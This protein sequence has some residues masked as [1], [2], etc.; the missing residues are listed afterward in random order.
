[1]IQ[2]EKMRKALI[3]L[4]IFS[5]YAIIIVC[6]YPFFDRMK[7]H[8]IAVAWECVVAVTQDLGQLEVW[9]AFAL[10]A[11]STIWDVVETC[12]KCKNGISDQ[13][14]QDEAKFLGWSTII[15][16]ISLGRAINWKEH[17][18]GSVKGSADIDMNGK[19]S[20]SPNGPTMSGTQPTHYV[21]PQ[22]Y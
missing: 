11:Y 21:G 3:T 14:C 12:K 15:T 16:L 17:G 8:A 10:H 13:D 19:V 9:G 1:M 6:A 18:R 2:L 4:S 5:L 20:L 7:P 22:K